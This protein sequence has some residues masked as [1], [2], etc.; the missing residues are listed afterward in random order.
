MI[1]FTCTFATIR[2]IFG[3]EGQGAEAGKR[4]G[5]LAKLVNLEPR[6]NLAI[7]GNRNMVKAINSDRL[8][9]LNSG[10]RQR[11]K[12]RFGYEPNVAGSNDKSRIS[13]GR[14]LWRNT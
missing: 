2:T 10:S 4:P 7:S 9:A 3:A 14:T 1:D 8:Q 13:T 12:D 6:R 5:R 11:L